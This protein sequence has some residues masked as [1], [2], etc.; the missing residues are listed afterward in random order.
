MGG[1]HARGAAGEAF[2][3]GAQ[4]R[5]PLRS[6]EGCELVGVRQPLRSDEGCELV[7]ETLGVAALERRELSFPSKS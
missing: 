6:D 2:R 5:Q 1:M 4:V 3:E 7:G